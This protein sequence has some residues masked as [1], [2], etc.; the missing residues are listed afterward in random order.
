LI[1]LIVG[2]RSKKHRVDKREE[3]GG[4]RDAKAEEE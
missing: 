3:C 2:E 4:G 1:R